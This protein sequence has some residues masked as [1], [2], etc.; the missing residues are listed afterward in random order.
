MEEKILISVEE[1]SEYTQI[2]K[3]KLRELTREHND[4]PYIK[5]GAKVLIIK[6]KLVSWFD[7]H[8]GEML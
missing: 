4:F 7:E 8:K 6:E 5:I 1:A 3:E 2:G